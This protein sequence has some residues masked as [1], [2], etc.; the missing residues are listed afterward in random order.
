MLLCLVEKTY[1]VLN[2]YWVTSFRS[3]FIRDSG[4]YA[5]T[6]HAF[7]S[8]LFSVR[9][10][11]SKI[12]EWLIVLENHSETLQTLNR[13]YYMV[14]WGQ[15]HFLRLLGQCT[16][17]KNQVFGLLGQWTHKTGLISGLPSPSKPRTYPVFGLLS[18]CTPRTWLILGLPSQSAPRTDHVFF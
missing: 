16:P 4:T 9:F 11:Q 8:A 2:R 14:L 6:G 17:W 3:L 13:T 5:H 18:Q 7:L 1:I 15:I 12:L 10:S